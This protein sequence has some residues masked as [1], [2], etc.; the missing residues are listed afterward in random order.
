M[1]GKRPAVLMIHAREGM[2]PKNL[3]LAEIWAKLGYVSFTADIFGYG[4]G[5]LPKESLKWRRRPRSTART[6]R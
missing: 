2:S 3:K 4:Q 5:V 6:A 1:T